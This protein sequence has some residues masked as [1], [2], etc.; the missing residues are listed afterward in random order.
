MKWLFYSDG[1]F[2]SSRNQQGFAFVVYHEIDGK[3][4]KQHLFYDGLIGGTNNRAEIYGIIK[5]LEF[6]RDNNI[7]EEVVIYT[8][9][10]YCIGTITKGYKQN[11]NKDLWAILFLLLQDNVKFQHIKGH[12]GDEGNSLADVWA[13]FGSQLGGCDND[14]INNE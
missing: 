4:V 12:A 5:S 14:L 9:S 6:I 8:D 2:S 11:K 3:L 13:V 1:A 7:K 10:M